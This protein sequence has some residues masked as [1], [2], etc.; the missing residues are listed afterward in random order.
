M[1]QHATLYLT[2]ALDVGEV[3]EVLAGQAEVGIRP[4]RFGELRGAG[5]VVVATTMAVVEIGPHLDGLRGYVR[6]RCAVVSP[7]FLQRVDDVR[8]VLGLVIEPGFRHGDEVW[9]WLTA[10]ARAGAGLIFLGG[11]FLD[12]RSQPL[13]APPGLQLVTVAMADEAGAA[14]PD[15][16]RVRRRAWALAAV[17]ERGLIETAAA[18]DGEA[19]LARLRRWVDL[20]GIRTELTAAERALIDAAPGA[21]PGRQVVDAI[22]RSEGLAVLAWALGAIDLPAHDEPA[23]VAAVAAAIGLLAEPVAAAPATL[24]APAELERLRRR[25]LAIHWRLRQHRLAPA[26]VDLV[27]LAQADFLGGFDLFGVALAE[28]D[29]AIGGEPITRA[30]PERI[31]AAMSI[32]RERHHASNWLRG[33]DADYAAIATPT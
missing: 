14:A 31:R 22:W 29:L 9:R 20:S 32:A 4:D 3:G 33:D 30:D 23:D 1:Y 19:R 27:R 5:V 25:Q 26:A 18:D 7:D 24:R 8:Q 17:A 28:R 11:A 13:A 15:A 16:A 2:R 12:D 10:L 6:A 21:L